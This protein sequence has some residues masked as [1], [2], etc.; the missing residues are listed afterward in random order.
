M[1]PK[2]W[3]E[4]VGTG[5]NWSELV[6]TG[7]T[8]GLLVAPKHSLPLAVLIWCHIRTAK[9][10]EC[11]GATSSP[12]IR[13]VP[14]SSDQF[15]PVPTSSDHSFGPIS[16]HPQLPPRRVS[17]TPEECPEPA[18]RAQKERSEVVGWSEL[19]GTGVYHLCL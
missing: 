7:R 9:G 2:E 19:V 10:S 1:G 18:R 5:R 4:V 15:R 11:L 3:S 17:E 13:P 12:E 14:T 16:K 8:W 6:G